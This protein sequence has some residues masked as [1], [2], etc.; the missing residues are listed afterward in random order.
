M[1]R[2]LIC[3]LLLSGCTGRQAAVGV[4]TGLSIAVVSVV[5][6][7]S[8]DQGK[9]AP[10]DG[11]ALIV[12]GGLGG[13]GIAGLSLIGFGVKAIGDHAPPDTP[14]TPGA[15]KNEIGAEGSSCSEALERCAFGL[16]CVQG[17]CKQAP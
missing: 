1:A 12:V 8:I 2:V 11:F 10:G 7:G 14:T 6:G 17:V 16:A 13:L 5:A 15:P 3:L 4:A 9:P